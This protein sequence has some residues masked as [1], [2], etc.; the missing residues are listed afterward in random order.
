MTN[1]V[2][3]EVNGYSLFNDIDDAELRDRNRA[4]VMANMCEQNTRNKK[5]SPKGMAL[6]IGY[7]HAIAKEQRAKVMVNFETFMG[8]RGFAKPI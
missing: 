2:K 5:V 1:Q 7:F 4:V 6:V 3:N 8:E